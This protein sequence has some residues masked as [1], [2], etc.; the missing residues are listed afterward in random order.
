MLIATQITSLIDRGLLDSD[1]VLAAKVNINDSLIDM[2][3]L[4]SNRKMMS[5]RQ[6]I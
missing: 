3:Y 5:R 6:G 1:E 2:K 4:N